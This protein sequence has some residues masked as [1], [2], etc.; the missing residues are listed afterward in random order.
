MGAGDVDT[1]LE[2]ELAVL[3]RVC[4]YGDIVQALDPT[5]AAPGTS[6]EVVAMHVGADLLKLTE[7]QQRCLADVGA[8]RHVP[9][10]THAHA[11]TQR[12]RER[13][14]ERETK[15]ERDRGRR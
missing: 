13:E 14:R 5:L 11:H 8:L 4:A 6:G 15:R 12:E 9:R 1:C 2:T 10:T 7:V 3:D